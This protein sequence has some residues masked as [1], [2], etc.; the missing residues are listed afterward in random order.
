MF[1]AELDLHLALVPSPFRGGGRPARALDGSVEPVR[2]ET[3]ATGIAPIGW[4]YP[5]VP[6]PDIQPYLDA[7]ETAP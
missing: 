6:Y 2:V 5:D 3:W 4:P 1:Y 7:L